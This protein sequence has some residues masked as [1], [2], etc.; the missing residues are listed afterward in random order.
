VVREVRDCLASSVAEEAIPEETEVLGC[1]G[2]DSP[3]WEERQP[4]NE[5]DCASSRVSDNV[6]IKP[7]NGPTRLVKD[8]FH[9]AEIPHSCLRSGA[10]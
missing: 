8:G 6:A 4:R 5:R 1:V 10:E 3:L 2:V 7:P 9:L